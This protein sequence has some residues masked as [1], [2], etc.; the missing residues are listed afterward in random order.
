[1][2]IRERLLIDAFVFQVIEAMGLDYI[3][4]HLPFLHR[5]HKGMPKSEAQSMYIKEASDASAA[6]NLHL[7]KLKNKTGS[8]EVWIGI[9]TTGVEINS[10]EQRIS[11]IHTNSHSSH[12]CAKQKTRISYFVWADIGKLYF[13][14]KKFEIRSIGYPVR[15]FTYYASTEDMARHMLWLC[16]VTH[17]FQLVVQPKMKEVK[18]RE[19]ELCRKKFRESYICDDTYDLPLIARIHKKGAEFSKSMASA[20]EDTSAQRVSVISNASS[21]TTSGIV[22]D[23]V[24]SID[25][26]DRE[27]IDVEIMN[28]SAPVLSLESLSLSEPID[29]SARKS[30]K[31]D[32]QSHSIT[33][34]A[35]NCNS[36]HKSKQQSDNEVPSSAN[37]IKSTSSSQSNTTIKSIIPSNPIIG[38]NKQIINILNNNQNKDIIEIKSSDPLIHCSSA[39]LKPNISVNT[40]C[41]KVQQIPDITV[42]SVN[43]S[44]LS[45]RSE[46]M[47]HIYENIPYFSQFQENKP[48]L[49]LKACPSLSSTLTPT[50]TTNT[51]QRTATRI[52]VSSLTRTHNKQTLSIFPNNV[53]NS[54][55]TSSTAASEP[56]LHTSQLWSTPS[57]YS[58]NR[59]N[60]RVSEEMTNLSHVSNI[61]PIIGLTDNISSN[62][63]I[64]T[65]TPLIKSSKETRAHSDPCSH[66]SRPP[67]N[68]NSLLTTTQLVKC[69][70]PSSQP[71]FHQSL[72]N[73]SMTSSHPLRLF[74]SDISVNTDSDLQSILIP[75]P[76][77]QYANHSNGNRVFSELS[78]SH[79]GVSTHFTHSFLQLLTF[80]HF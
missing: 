15:K 66:Y 17:Q 69:S 2:I 77:P 35:L 23:K 60:L 9:C 34:I 24:Q 1:M 61:N 55:K 30:H 13:D 80:F 46:S 6:H 20:L 57:P 12:T 8:A 27:D 73:I 26:S 76:P 68:T 62:I 28:A 3:V 79:K 42:R 25:D 50:T 22:S 63:Y 21:N 75:P 64:E 70:A 59:T 18:R 67:I 48:K 65:N 37:S 51:T 29:N 54:A 31:E 44:K 19:S 14:K 47:N 5:D 53:S 52:G 11:S 78:A 41:A 40:S 71:T 38:T 58:P 36:Y 43:L 7:Y 74:A 10:E 32:K 72:N 56:N 33:D 49:L 45:E 16:K 4:R 39:S